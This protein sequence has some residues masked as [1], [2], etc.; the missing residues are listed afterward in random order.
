M[1]TQIIS[2]HQSKDQI[3]IQQRNLHP[4]YVTKT[5]DGHNV[6]PLKEKFFIPKTLWKPILS[7]YHMVVQNSGIQQT[8]QTRRS[9]PVWIGL[10]KDI[11]EHVKHC[12]DCQKCKDPCK[13]NTCIYL[14][15]K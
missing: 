2:E 6:I 4:E 8:E 11:E 1:S 7:R 9:H 3:L 15:R 10:S 5:D 12:H 13:K 14:S